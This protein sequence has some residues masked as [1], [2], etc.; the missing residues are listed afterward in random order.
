VKRTIVGF[1]QDD[2]GAWVAELSCLHNQHVRH[3]PPFRER[4][5]VV[6]ESGRASRI[7]TDIECPLCER[8]E[9]PRR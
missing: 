8:G 9:P 7:G 2:E 3:Q 4:P 5:W 6:T 1:H